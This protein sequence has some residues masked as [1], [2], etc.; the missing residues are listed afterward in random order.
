MA[1][2]GIVLLEKMNVFNFRTLRA[3]ISKIGFFS[4][5]W[6]LGAVIATVGLQAAAVY[7]PFLQAALHTVPLGWRDWALMLALAAPIFLVSEL[8]KWLAWRR[9][10][11]SA[12]P[13]AAAAS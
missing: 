7:T 4:N 9:R 8:V 6:V 10:S 2:T 13:R 11:G 1:F 5:W 3:P 12:P